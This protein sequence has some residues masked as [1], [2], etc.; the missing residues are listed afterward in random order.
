M[1]NQPGRLKSAV[2]FKRVQENRTFRPRK[3]RR[4]RRVGR[5]WVV[6]NDGRNDGVVRRVWMERTMIE[7]FERLVSGCGRPG[8]EIKVSATDI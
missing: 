4:R 6:M 7:L 5:R 2:Y 8:D 1:H 3:M